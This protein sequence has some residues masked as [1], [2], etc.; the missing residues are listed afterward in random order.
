MDAR[1]RRA[2]LI[3]W[4]EETHRLQRKLGIAFAVLGVVAVG[5]LFVSTT[6]GGFAIFG[7]A[8][9]ALVSF[10]VTAAHNAAHRQKLVELAQVARNGGKP[11]QT[12]H[13]R[14]HAGSPSASAPASQAEQHHQG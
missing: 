10:W 1:D 3:G 4:I 9:T 2:Q 13:R 12:A 14:W 6:I 8:M 7:V 5:L 11:L